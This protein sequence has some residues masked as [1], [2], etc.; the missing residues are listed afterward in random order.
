M[1]AVGCVE[2]IKDRIG[3]CQIADNLMPVLD[4]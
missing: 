2:A 4:G 1:A 3:N